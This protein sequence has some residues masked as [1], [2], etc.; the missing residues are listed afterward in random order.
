MFEVLRKLHAQQ[1]EVLA[2]RS[3]EIQRSSH[4]YL[5]ENSELR[6]AYGET[7][8]RVAASH[9]WNSE[10]L[11]ADL[12]S[13]IGG[14]PTLPPEWTVNEKKL[15]CLIRCADA[16]QVD[17]TR[18]PLTLYAALGP[19]GI[20]EHHWRAQS[21]L[22]RPTLKGDAIHFT[23]SSSFTAADAEPWW[24]AFDLANV[25][26]RELRASNAILTDMSEVTF[27]AQRVAGAET[28]D[29]F[30]KYVKTTK[31]RPIDA[32]IRV[33]DPLKLAR[34][35]GGRN[36]YGSSPLIPFRELI[37]NAAD[38]IRARRALEERGQEFGKIQITVEQHPVDV[39][40]CLVHIDDDGIGMSERI[41]STTLVD[42]GKS[43]W[44]SSAIAD[45]FPGLKATNVKHIGKFGIGFFAVFEVSEEVRVISKRYDVGLQD[46]R[47]LDFRGLV[48]RP[49]LRE[50]MPSE[51]PRDV[52]TRITLSISKDVTQNSRASE[53]GISEYDVPFGYYPRSRR[54]GGLTLMKAVMGICS[55]LDIEVQY[56]DLR[57]GDTLTHT[58]NIY[59]KNAEVF[60]SELPLH[61]DDEVQTKHFVASD[62]L[63]V[64]KAKNGDAYGRAALDL[65]AI[66]NSRTSPRACVSVGG[67]VSIGS[68]GG[69][70]TRANVSIPYFGVI[71]GET[72][73]AARNVFKLTVPE[74][75]VEDWLQTQISRIDRDL[76]R[77][78]EIMHIASFALE[79][80][81]VDSGLPFA[82]HKGNLITASEVAALARSTKKIY[83]PMSW[84]YET[85]PEV[86]GYNTLRPE[87]F[88]ASLADGLLVLASGSDR[89]LEDDDAREIKKSGS[90]MVDKEVILRRWEG[91]RPLVNILERE[92]A[93]ECAF[94]LSSE[95]IFS[96]KIASL[97]GKRSVLIMQAEK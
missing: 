87:Y 44:T 11:Y 42:F 50:L 30:S 56:T 20:S 4:I 18:A 93:S 46:A 65:D 72:E 85:W 48:T 17:R 25:L 43:L 3:W 39:D 40:R 63:S 97:S 53:S 68:R 45:E 70:N 51:L 27:S 74:G 47:A 60:I 84:R 78:S 23:S 49:L 9:H 16:A 67:I 12:S 88:E 90:G 41:L 89:L 52:S 8:G 95:T 13:Q 79:A 82:F 54:S 7:I 77:T 28:P 38:A 94:T 31:W 2:T 75:S 22:N 36:L 86:L 26:D 83:L 96:T 80:L 10:R 5:I 92:W 55:F 76:L 15:G 34:T 1:A 62:N 58:A 61:S 21:K 6:E 57:N 32:T 19:K 66:I 35:L 71:E 14:S 24:I 64:L 29:T 37:Q 69:L 81:G 59:E 33:T 91:C 73:R